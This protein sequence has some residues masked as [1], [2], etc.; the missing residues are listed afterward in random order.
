MTRASETEIQEASTLLSKAFLQSEDDLERR[1][2]DLDGDVLAIVREIGI[3]MISTIFG[4]VGRRATNLAKRDGMHSHR[5]ASA[6]ISTVLGRVTVA[7]PYLRN[8]RTKE[9]ARPVKDGLGLYRPAEDSRGRA[10]I[11][12]FWKRGFLRD[13]SKS[14]TVTTLG[15][16]RC[17]GSSKAVLSEQDPMSSND[18][19]LNELRSA[20]QFASGQESPRG[21]SSL[22]AA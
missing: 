15:E 5:Q 14:T 10:R 17:C 1:I 12:R 2:L 8:P 21:L 11:G 3:A 6:V 16:R 7:S 9:S 20:F 4:E 22:M 18:W 19:I 13:A